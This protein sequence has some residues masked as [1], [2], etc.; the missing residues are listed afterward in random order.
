MPP[1]GQ[2]VRAL[3]WATPRHVRKGN[4]RGQ[5]RLLGSL[6]ALVGVVVE[7]REG[8][9]SGPAA[10]FPGKRLILPGWQGVDFA[11]KRPILPG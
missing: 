7:W 9:F 11:G 8:K 10:D 3:P 5:G 4:H 1:Q 2:P 6:R